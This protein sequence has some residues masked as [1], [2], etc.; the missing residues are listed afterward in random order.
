MNMKSVKTSAL[1][2]R[3]YLFLGVNIRLSSRIIWQQSSRANGTYKRN[4]R[5]QS[6]NKLRP[7]TPLTLATATKLS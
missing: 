4:Y 5:R 6:V 3:C 7:R 2:S 1:L